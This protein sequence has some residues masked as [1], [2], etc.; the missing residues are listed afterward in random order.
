YDI[1]RLA[2]HFG[3]SFESAVYRLR[4]LRIVTQEEME[5]LLERRADATHLQNALDLAE[6]LERPDRQRLFLHQ[7]MGLA[8]EAY[9]R[10]LISRRKLDE[11]AALLALPEADVDQ[12]LEHA[13]LEIGTDV[14][15][16]DVRLPE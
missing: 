7:F 4:N 3:V 12:L 15:P 10:E 5:S 16:E 6:P 2:H 13:G 1:V 8:L 14:G 9:R 11:L